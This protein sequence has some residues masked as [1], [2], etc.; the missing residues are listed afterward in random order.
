MK[1][2]LASLIL[3]G[4][5]LMARPLHAQLQTF[6]IISSATWCTISVSTSVPT[7][8]DNFNGSCSGLMSSR[9]ALK[10]SNGTG[11]LHAGFS[12][13]LS[14]QTTSSKY[15]E[16]ISSGEKVEYALSSILPLYLMSEAAASA[17]TVTVMQATYKGAGQ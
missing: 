5:L 14:T 2:I 13:Q 10:I 15:G 16:T 3:L 1:K 12:T 11:T 9:T 7:R 17:P 8:V 4:G 6:I